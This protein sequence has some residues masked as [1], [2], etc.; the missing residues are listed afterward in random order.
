[1]GGGGG[2]AP[3]CTSMSFGFGLCDPRTHLASL[4]LMDTKTTESGL[5]ESATVFF[6]DKSTT[7]PTP[8]APAPRTQPAKKLKLV[9][10]HKACTCT[11]AMRCGA[12]ADCAAPNPTPHAHEVQ[13]SLCAQRRGAAPGKTVSVPSPVRFLATR[14]RF[15]A[16]I[17]AASLSFFIASSCPR[18][19]AASAR[20][21][22]SR[23]SWT[24]RARRSASSFALCCS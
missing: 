5:V 16:G 13:L 6:N 18:H 15:H 1:M 8:Q 7:R 11:R 17:M 20:A 23:C 3:S 4:W 9:H 24:C 21:S 10:T 22:F 19:R 14:S 12:T 2:G